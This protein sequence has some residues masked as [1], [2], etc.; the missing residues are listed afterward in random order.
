MAQ[1]VGI[2]EQYGLATSAVDASVVPAGFRRSGNEQWWRKGSDLRH[3]VATGLR[4]DRGVDSGG[5]QIYLGVDLVALNELTA[6]L[7]GTPVR[8]GFFTVSMDLDI[9]G[10]ANR[11]REWPLGPGI[12]A[13]SV[14]SAACEELGRIM[15]AFFGEFG[16]LDALV[17]RYEAAD[18]RVAVN[19]WRWKHVAALLLLGE[20]ERG[21]A[22]LR[23]MLETAEPQERRT[24]EEAVASVETQRS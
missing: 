1:R 3:R 11:Y 17:A 12:D 18:P 19:E 7:R 20:R 15:P 24:V 4:K 5:F 10:G 22:V 8:K 14:T 23:S 6:R 9:A 21:L 2:E 16:T 13:A